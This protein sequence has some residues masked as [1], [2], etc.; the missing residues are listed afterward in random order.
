MGPKCRSSVTT[1]GSAQVV[2][3][4]DTT[5]PALMA[6]RKDYLAPPMARRA[7][8]RGKRPR[9][10]VMPNRSC[11]YCSRLLVRGFRL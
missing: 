6:A 7:V 8:R 4:D 5:A 9:G 1:L 11:V 2:L 3:G 10:T